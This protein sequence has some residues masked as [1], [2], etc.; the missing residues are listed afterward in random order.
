MCTMEYSSVFKRDEGI[1]LVAM[2]VDPGIIKLSKTSLT[3][4]DI[5]CD[6]TY[7]WNLKKNYLIIKEKHGALWT[8]LIPQSGSQMTSVL[9]FHQHENKPQGGYVH[10]GST[11]YEEKVEN[12]SHYEQCLAIKTL[13]WVV[14]DEQSGVSLLLCLFG[15]ETKVQEIGSLAY[16]SQ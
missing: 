16:C 11:P 6:T 10:R 1:S 5:S 2:L 8:E 14:L 9:C 7:M 13:Y 3:K 15:L 12:H 4:K